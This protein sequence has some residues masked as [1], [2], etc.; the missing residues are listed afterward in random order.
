MNHLSLRARR[1]RLRRGSVLAA[2]FALTLAA[3]CGDDDDDAGSSGTDAADVT[4]ATDAPADTTAD[5]DAP[6]DTTADTAAESTTPSDTEPADTEPEAAEPTPGGE[7]TVGT[8]FDAFGLE[9]TTF[10]GGVTDAYIAFALYDPL[11]MLTPEGVP[12][13][14][15]AESVETDDDQTYTIT[16][17]DGVMFQDGTPLDA[18]AVKVNIERHMDPANRSRALGNAVNIAS[19]T[20]IDPLTVEIALKF[21]W[22]AFPELLAGN[23][24]LIASP[25]AIA[26]GTL[27]DNPVGSGPYSLEERVPGDHTTVVKN[28]DYWQEGKPYLDEITFRVMLDDDV[29]Q[30]SVAN[31]EI[32]A[33]QSIRADTLANAEDADGVS[34]TKTPG[35]VNTIHVNTSV[36][37]VDDARVRQALAYALDYEALN[38]VIFGGAAE[39][40]HAFISEDSPFNDPD[41]AWPEYDPERAAQLI[42]EYEAEVGPVSF[43]FRCYS[44]PSRAKLA[45]L[46]VQM[47][48]AVGIDVTAEISDQTTLVLD[49]FQSNYSVACFSGGA[50]TTDPDLMWYSS[51]YSTSAT[52]YS[53][54]SNPE[55]DA[56][57]DAGRTSTEEAD[58][59]AAY[60]TVQTLL[61]SESPIIQYMASPWGWVV[62]DDVAGLVAL[63]GGD[64]VPSEVYRTD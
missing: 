43:A 10:V 21:P 59:A 25:T 47:W 3:A 38:Q 7:M 8:V 31:G 36:A 9:P 17:H 51:L 61:A 46:A 50:D 60:S 52:N 40:T 6:A 34:A 56:A 16:L 63:P 48:T 26:S 64:F 41:V 19:V 14:Y 20:V 29:R 42:E 49:L 33:A 2:C 1:S 24:G 11:M 13:P 54:Y 53:K 5:T 12:E 39:T 58:R 18:E 4:S 37:P 44:E 15:L 57:L 23:L 30:A 27:N 62:S 22:I 45:E 32:Q 55:M 28:P 35:R